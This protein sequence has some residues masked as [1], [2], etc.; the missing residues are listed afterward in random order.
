MRLE[1]RQ[2][3]RRHVDRQHQQAHSERRPVAQR[4]QRCGQQHQRSVRAARH[5]AV[6]QDLH[7]VSGVRK[8]NLGKLRRRGQLQPSDLI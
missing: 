4:H 7:G 6:R 1:G 5:Q 2:G 3:L 8:T